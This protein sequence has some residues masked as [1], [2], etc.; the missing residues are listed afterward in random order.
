MLWLDWASLLSL[1]NAPLFVVL[2]P[3][4]P[5]G[6]ELLF[7]RGEEGDAGEE[8]LLSVSLLAKSAKLT[9]LAGSVTMLGRDFFRF[10]CS[11]ACAAGRKKS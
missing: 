8:P 2:G 7:F 5:V 3:N 4:L 9:P 1:I 11:M 10:C 6:V